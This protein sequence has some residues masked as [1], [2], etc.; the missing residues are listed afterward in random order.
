MRKDWVPALEIHLQASFQAPNPQDQAGFK[1][2]LI[3]NP[4]NKILWF[5][6]A[7]GQTWIVAKPSQKVVSLK[8]R[9]SMQNFVPDDCSP[10]KIKPS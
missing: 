9:A 3:F 7:L 10:A 4:V 2:Y 1:S 5:Y 8:K 6:P